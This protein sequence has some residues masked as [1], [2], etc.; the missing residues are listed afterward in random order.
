MV[1]KLLGP[2]ANSYSSRYTGASYKGHAEEPYFAIRPGVIE[3]LLS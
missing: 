2:L 3:P 1:W